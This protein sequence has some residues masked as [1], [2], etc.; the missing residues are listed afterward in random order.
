L[1]GMPR[2]RQFKHAALIAL[3]AFALRSAVAGAPPTTVEAAMSRPTMSRPLRCRLNLSHR[4]VRG[5]T[6]DGGR[7]RRCA[8]CGKDKTDA[9]ITVPA[10]G[11]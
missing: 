1:F 11:P 4:W 6:E 9:G 2:N 5:T 8:R 10:I 7:F 3:S